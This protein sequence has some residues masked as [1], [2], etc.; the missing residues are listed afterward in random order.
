[1]RSGIFSLLV[2][3]TG[4][5]QTPLPELRI[6]AIA[7]GSVLFVRNLS[8]QPLTAYL[9]ELVDYPGSSF[10]FWQDEIPGG[11][12]IAPGL[13]KRIQITH[14]TVGAVP[15]YVKL[16]AAIYADGSTVGV[17]EKVA[18]MVGRRKAQLDAARDLIARLES[19]KP[20]A[21]AEAA[22]GL[23]LWADS[24]KSEGRPD[25]NSARWVNRA[26]QRT[27]VLHFKQKLA[28]ETLA[29]VLARVRAAERQLAS[30]KTTP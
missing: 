26:A 15:D 6:D 21:T 18:L 1:M 11:E 12:P 27:L 4:L 8:R 19:V 29:D 23:S 20:A 25:Y 16:R 30:S 13:E 5:A 28:A 24:L 3:A 17:P 2:I 22:E 10:T 7:G 9:I 14:M